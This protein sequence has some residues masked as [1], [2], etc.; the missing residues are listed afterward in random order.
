MHKLE[1]IES[2]SAFLDFLENP[3]DYKELVKEVKQACKDHK[4]L[5]EK[6]RKIKDIDKWR[7]S[8][9]ARLN[10]LSEE[11]DRRV[12]SQSETMQ[13][14]QE[15]L[16][17]GQD[18]IAQL[19]RE[20]QERVKDLDE[21]EKDVEK[22]EAERAKVNQLKEEYESKLQGIREEK[23]RMKQQ[24]EQLIAVAGGLS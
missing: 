11:L 4:E 23:D 20:I 12:T 17:E 24:K 15:A 21:R 13:K 19:N 5:V 8:E 10:Q 7:A 6:Q 1:Q 22:L 16:K 14:H 2:F 9:E 18:A 3:N